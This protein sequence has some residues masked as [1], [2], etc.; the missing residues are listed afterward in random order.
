MVATG[1]VSSGETG[2]GHC[3]PVRPF[4]HPVET[5]REGEG[6]QF[7][8]ITN[9][10][11]L[12]LGTIRTLEWFFPQKLYPNADCYFHNGLISPTSLRFLLCPSNPARSVSAP[13]AWPS[14][15]NINFQH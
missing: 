12:I 4:G 8:Y 7:G 3:A 13:A 9:E 5:G 6:S 1:N 14:L 10:D 15:S 11:L 2:G